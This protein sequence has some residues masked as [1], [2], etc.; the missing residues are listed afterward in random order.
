MK[1]IVLS[2]LFISTF[3]VVNAQDFKTM[4]PE[5]S[6]KYYFDLGKEALYNKDMEAAVE[7]FTK[8]DDIEN[9]VFE[10][11]NK[12][13]K[14]KEYYFSQEDLNEA[15]EKGSYSKASKKM[16]STG[17]SDQVQNEIDN[18]IAE[19]RKEAGQEYNNKQYNSAAEKFV[20]TYNLQKNSGTDDLELMYYAATSYQL[21]KQLK[22]AA[23]IYEQLLDVGYD[24]IKTTYFATNVA[25]NV[26]NSFPNKEMWEKYKIDDTQSKMYKD[27]GSETSKD[28]TKDLYTYAASVNNELN[29]YKRASEIAEEGLNKFNGDETL[30]SILTNAINGAGK[31]V[32]Y[33]TRLREK[34]KQNPESEN[35]LYNLGIMLSGDNA[36][37]ADLT[38][39]ESIFRKIFELNP[40][41]TN[42]ALN[43]A[44]L[45]IKDD[46]DLVKQLNSITGSTSADNAKYEQLLKQRKS[47]H[48]DVLPYLEQAAKAN[49]E[50]LTILKNLMISYGILGKN[51]ERDM[52]KQQIGSLEK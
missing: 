31:S 29:N 39:A 40:N 45:L 44:A 11:K 10:V 12:N 4:T 6:A 18:M 52:L 41:N 14:Q 25:G 47:L 38:E 36:T 3:L 51:N 48:A 28:I 23:A 19:S 22:K 43:L 32:P 46:A 49:P 9:G 15:I 27:W 20:Q 8:L 24:G 37:A 34:I 17:Y 2:T 42:V 21:D 50:D 26:R 16:V 33:I 7:A 13:T 35:D 30:Q 5:A 1:K